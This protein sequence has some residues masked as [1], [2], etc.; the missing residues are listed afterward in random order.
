VTLHRPSNVDSK[1]ALTAIFDILRLVSE[2]V[3]LIYPVHPR[4]KGMLE[5]YGLLEKLTGLNSLSLIDPLGYLDFVRLMKDSRFVL[6]DSG[7]IQEESTALG[8]P[9]LTMRENTERPVT[10]TQGTNILVGKDVRRIVRG[11]TNVLREKFKR[12]TVPALWDGK[13]S[14]RIG[15]IIRNHLA[16][17][18]NGASVTRWLGAE[19]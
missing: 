5:R 1:G 6:T 18:Q 8:I 9:C 3:E 17:G 7:G 12:G 2:K 16:D 15:G 11:V 14:Q 13:A 4:A 19:G 10:V